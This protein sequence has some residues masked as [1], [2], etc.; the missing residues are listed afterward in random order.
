MRDMVNKSA[1]LAVLH[2]PKHGL[3][4]LVTGW[5]KGIKN[6]SNMGKRENQKFILMP[7]SKLKSRISQL[8]EKH[9]IRFLEIEEANTLIAS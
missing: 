4:T 8:C 2:C 3:G 9:G 6:E 7:L 1:K 5:N